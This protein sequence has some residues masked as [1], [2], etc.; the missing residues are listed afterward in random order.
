MCVWGGGEGGWGV[1]GYAALGAA[2]LS[3]GESE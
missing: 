3:C 1:G 2:F